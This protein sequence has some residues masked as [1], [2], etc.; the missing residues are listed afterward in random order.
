MMRGTEWYVMRDGRIAEVRAYFLYED[1]GDAQL[2]GFPYS[3]RDY[4]AASA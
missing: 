4:L 2:A 1:A 3:E